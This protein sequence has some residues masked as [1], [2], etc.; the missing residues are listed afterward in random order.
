MKFSPVF[1]SA[2][3]CI[4]MN[5]LFKKHFFLIRNL[6]RLGLFRSILQQGLFGKVLSLEIFCLYPGFRFLELKYVQKDL[7]QAP[8]A[9]IPVDK[10]KPR[11]EKLFATIQLKKVIL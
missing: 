2:K 4:Q 1:W 10:N 11:S 5:K 6:K 3:V 7:K 8:R 9:I